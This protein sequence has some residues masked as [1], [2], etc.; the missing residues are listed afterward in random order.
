M[1]AQRSGRV[2]NI[3][4]VGA[5]LYEPFGAWYHATKYAVEG[6]SN[7][8]RLEVAPFGI[9]VVVVAPGPIVT[10]WSTIARDSLLAT[11]GPGPY[12]DYARRAHK[13]LTDFD[14]PSRASHPGV[15][16]RKIVK[17]ATTMRPAA[18]YPVGRGARLIRTS[19]DL[20][21]SS[22]FDQVVSRIFGTR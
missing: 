18:V 1:R 11:S 15:V 5:R 12:G 19:V 14:R 13:V 2:I 22:A 16:G 7:S 6:L 4:S 3:S 8:L 20:L 10:E 9:D 17:A 21:P